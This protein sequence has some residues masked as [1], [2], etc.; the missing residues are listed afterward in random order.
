[1]VGNND[2]RQ[3]GNTMDMQISNVNMSQGDVCTEMSNLICEGY[4]VFEALNKK[5]TQKE[6]ISTHERSMA[7]RV[8]ARRYKESMKEYVNR[9]E[10]KRDN[11]KNE[12]VEI[13]KASIAILHMCEILLF[14]TFQVF[15][16][17]YTY[18]WNISN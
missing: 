18:T 17:I 1:M 14:G 6:A 13:M 12:I 4:I 15:I 7:I 2:D 16:W 10:F 9:M 8:A 3:C 11:A 5:C